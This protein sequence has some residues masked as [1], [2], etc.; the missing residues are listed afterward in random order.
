MSKFCTSCGNQVSLEEKFC[1]QCGN[2]ICEEK[3]ITKSS[4]FD[5][6]LNCN[7]SENTYKFTVDKM[8]FRF[9][10]TKIAT[11]ATVKNNILSTYMKCNSKI[12][13][14]KNLNGQINISDISS[15]EYKQYA[16]LAL[17]DIFLFVVVLFVT[18]ID[19]SYFIP[20]ALV[21]GVLL[22]RTLVPSLEIKTKDNRKLNILFSP[23]DNGK[24]MLKLI[25][26]ITGEEVDENSE[27]KIPFSKKPFVAVLVYAIVAFILAVI[28][29]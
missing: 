29:A 19:P 1:K 22:W 8:T 13:N 9:M 23:Q 21:S 6:K 24:I 20:Y 14:K 11:T 12:L 18:A 4:E 26:Q 15:A 17:L 27:I 5:K 28:F 2:K 16:T 10:S 25:S 3:E 7:T